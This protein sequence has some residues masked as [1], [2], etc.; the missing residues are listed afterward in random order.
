MSA[1]N[2]P[3]AP[4]P[5]PLG[6]DPTPAS[7]VVVPSPVSTPPA[8]PPSKTLT[9]AEYDA[10]QQRASNYDLIAADPELA[11]KV[12]DH[13]RAR[14]GRLG[15]PVQ[16]PAATPN[17]A[18]QETNSHIQELVKR[19]AQLEVQL[20]KQMHPDMEEVGDDMSKLIHRYGMSLDDAYRFSKAAKAPASQKPAQTPPVA[21]TAETNHS[22]GSLDTSAISLADAEKRI[23][24]PKAT[25]HMDD[26]LALAWQTAKQQAGQ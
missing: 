8:T 20:F 11:P 6:V 24:D 18:T 7:P 1:I 13:F 22:A 9:Q 10:L 23:N 19:Q 3:P 2:P 16:T 21:P 15:A 14:T 5:S 25:P 17:P 26:A 12:V 4:V